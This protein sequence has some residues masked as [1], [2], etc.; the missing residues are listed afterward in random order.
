MSDKDD[1][2]HL[3][4]TIW[5]G[6]STP[7][8]LQVSISLLAVGAAVFT[9]GFW[10][11]K[12]SGDYKVASAEARYERQITELKSQ[13]AKKPVATE[14]MLELVPDSDQASGVIGF[15]DLNDDPAI[16]KD[17]RTQEFSVE[18]R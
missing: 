2:L 16:T 13:L 3:F 1:K 18:K 4:G 8:K 11:G 5:D 15:P 12:L 17:G 10:M 6:L 14:Y 9:G 7:Q